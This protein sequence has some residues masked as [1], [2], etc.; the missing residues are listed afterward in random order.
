MLRHADGAGDAGDRDVGGTDCGGGLIVGPG[1][2]SLPSA[3]P[4]H[5]RQRGG[6]WHPVEESLKVG[7]GGSLGAAG[8]TASH[9]R[10]RMWRNIRPPDWWAAEELG[11]LTSRISQELE[12]QFAGCPGIGESVVSSSSRLDPVILAET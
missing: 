10:D 9:W 1:Y 11:R 4:N 5:P 3:P 12:E 2:A 8:I 6:F 7:A